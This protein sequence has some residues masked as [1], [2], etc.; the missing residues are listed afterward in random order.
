MTGS[1]TEAPWRAVARRHPALGSALA[2][3]NP[4][5]LTR[6]T[7][8]CGTPILEDEGVLL[9]SERDPEREAERFVDPFVRDRVDMV[10]AIGFGIGLH[11]AKLRER[12]PCV[13]AVYEPDAARLRAALE[14]ESDFA[15]VA[16][17]GVHFAA[18]PA[19]LAQRV[20]EHYVS[21][22]RIQ[23]AIHPSARRLCPD[24]V[25]EA[26]RAVGAAKDAT[27]VTMATR[28]HQSECWA[29]QC[30][31]NAPHYLATPGLGAIA[32]RF[33]GRTA[34]IASA[35]PSLDKQ[36]PRLAEVQDEVLT[37]A[38]GPSVGAL[39]RA[40]IR[41]DFV[42]LLESND[43]THQLTHSGPTDDLNLILT[44]KAHP[45]L[46]ELPARSRFVA[47]TA[48]DTLAIWARAEL[49]ADEIVLHAAPSV[50]IQ[51]VWVAAALGA[52]PIL[53]IGQDLAF[54][55]GR[56]YASGSCYER[57]EAESE[58]D[59]LF[60]YTHMEDRIDAYG[61]DADRLASVTTQREVWVPGWDGEPVRSCVSYAS[62]REAYRGVG[63]SLADSGIRLVNCTEGGAAI[64]GVE[65]RGF[66]AML[67]EAVS[68]A[69]GGLAAALAIHDGW[70]PP[71]TAPLRAAITDQ[72]GA[73]RR[74]QRNASRATRG[75]AA[76]R[77]AIA[78]TQR[79]EDWRPLLECI[80]RLQ[81]RLSRNLQDTPWLESM[82][83]AELQAALPL[84]HKT[85]RANPSPAAA[86]EEALA[87]FEAADRGATRALA[88]LERFAETVG[89][90]A[91]RESS[92]RDP[93]AA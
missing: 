20:S 92:A 12:H 4:S 7:S 68:P 93:E 87:L 27:D 85:D 39:R 70:Q 30:A 22:L 14:L 58:D 60:R 72:R 49:D 19:E 8:A 34:V 36:L 73:L 52:N 2:A 37:I 81:A 51:A 43:V 71:S 44:P 64:D 45:G 9:A 21:G 54:T 40:G 61:G 79:P 32:G 10:V 46:Y 66:A 83:Q 15:W 74:V 67:D 56:V 11:L 69:V 6:R 91:P 5:R 35:G 38:V 55:E 31:D 25:R 78:G 63:R 77:D 84:L 18:T 29:K 65:Q 88:T 50:A 17:E 75:L 76:R 13:L 41:P 48:G 47:Y 1:P 16:E 90:R 28:V 53:L 57:I 82:V 3:A 42:H 33:S 80:A 89:R 62:F 23:I 24:A 86:V 26:V 59:G